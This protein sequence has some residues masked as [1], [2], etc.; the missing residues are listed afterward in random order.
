MMET[1]EQKIEYCE[2][3][4]RTIE[5][6]DSETFIDEYLV[7]EPFRIYKNSGLLFI[8]LQSG[9]NYYGEICATIEI[10]PDNSFRVERYGESVGPFYSD[11]LYDG[12]TDALYD[13]I[14]Q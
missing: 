10:Q 11:D 12:L 3:M 2:N 6:M 13:I 9:V 14:E 1:R 4:G 8:D 5:Q 7:G